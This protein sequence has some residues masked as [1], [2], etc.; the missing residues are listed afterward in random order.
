MSIDMVDIH[1]ILII[2]IVYSGDV[3]FV[4]KLPDADYLWP[5]MRYLLPPLSGAFVRHH[6]QNASWRPLEMVRGLAHLRQKAL[7]YTTAS[8]L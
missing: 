5:E 2:L 7:A 1:A 3:R 8:W 4:G 6:S